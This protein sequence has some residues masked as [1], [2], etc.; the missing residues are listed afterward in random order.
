M[1]ARSDK[2]DRNFAVPSAGNPPRITIPGYT[3]SEPL[4]I[5][6]IRSYR[7][8]EDA[9]GRR[10]VV[11][12]ASAAQRT[13]DQATRLR[14]EYEILRALDCEGVPVALDMVAADGG[15]AIVFADIRGEPLLREAGAF[16]LGLDAFFSV[17]LQLVE[18]VGTLHRHDIIHKDI[19]PA[20]IVID[21][22]AGRV[23]LADFGL[24][25]RLPRVH[26]AVVSP[27]VL[28]FRRLDGA[29]RLLQK[30]TEKLPEGPF[31]NEADAC[32]VRL[33]E[34]RQARAACLL[35]H[36][37]FLELSQRHQ[38]LGEVF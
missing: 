26:Q 23:M 13:P 20:N 32:A 7:A 29:W 18:I 37:A 22:V 1:V 12:P 6:I 36:S 35:A 30:L 27:E 2:V 10:V 9:T 38:R 5:D 21:R 25:S 8:V 14:R 31:A 28:A 24:A 15:G 16:P 3:V 17:A 19:N 4:G 34:H 11:K 33:V